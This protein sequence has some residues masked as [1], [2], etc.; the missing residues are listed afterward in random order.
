MT[1]LKL[2]IIKKFL[3]TMSN[4]TPEICRAVI[5]NNSILG[6]MSARYLVVDNVLGDAGD[7]RWYIARDGKEMVP[8]PPVAKRPPNAE[9][10]PIYRKIASFPSF[11]LY[12]NTIALP[13]F[14]SNLKPLNSIDDL[15][16]M[17]FSYQLNRV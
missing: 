9:L 4:L 7:V 15:V 14:V 12:E 6:M 10:I 5:R 3:P 8:S 11:S 17:L 16:Q 1:P 13:S 2:E